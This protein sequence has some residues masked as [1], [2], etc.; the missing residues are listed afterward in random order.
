MQIWALIQ[1]SFRDAIDRKIFWI[2]ILVSVAIAGAMGCISFDDRGVDVM[3]G[4]WQFESANWSMGGE[5]LRGNVGAIVVHILADLYLGWV[6]MILALVSTAGMIPAFL[7]RGRVDLVLSKPMSREALFMGKYLGAMVFMLLQATVFVLL[8]FL[9]MGFRWGLW[10]PGYLWLIPLIV[11]MFSYLYGFSALFGVMT[12]SATSSLLLT[13]LAWI[14]I[15]TPQK[16]YEFLVTFEAQVDPDRVWQKRVETLRW[17]VPKTQDIAHI[18]GNLIDAS[19]MTDVIGPDDETMDEED[20]MSPEMARSAER[21]LADVNPYLS[22]GSS[23]A[24]ECALLGVTLAIF[25]RR[26]Y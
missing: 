13:L 19:L 18:A 12:R 9:V 26:D 16:T 2:M 14:V 24:F 21:R 6:G 1:D 23:L 3:F 17:M 22:I 5:E 15:W 20:R 10:L 25:R 7:E 4:M 8:S 11:L